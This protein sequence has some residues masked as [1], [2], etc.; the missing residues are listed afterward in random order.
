MPKF[1]LIGALGRMGL[2]VS[3]VAQE[4][5]DVELVGGVIGSDTLN[6]NQNFSCYDNLGELIQT[7]GKPDFIIDFSTPET[8]AKYCEEA[9]MQKIPYITG[10]TGFTDT[11]IGLLE[12]CARQNLVFWSSNMSKGIWLQCKLA[13]FAANV[14]GKDYDVNILETHHTRKKDKPSGTALMIQ[15]AM[16]NDAPI[17]SLRAGNVTGTHIATFHGEYDYITII[18]EAN[19]R[20]M[21]AIGAIDAALWLLN[22]K[23]GKLY[24]LDDIFHAPRQS[25]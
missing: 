15:K 4:R 3:E 10:V 20:K 2:A 7:H 9:A 12:N 24:S 17:T 21:Y 1:A 8:S 18:H 22:Q 14:L 19:N 6:A 11:Q 23:P 25:Q 5:T 16:G 13:A